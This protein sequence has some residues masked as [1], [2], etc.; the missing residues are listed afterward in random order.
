MAK[1]ITFAISVSEVRGAIEQI[2]QYQNELNRKCELLCQRLS[3]EGI[4]IAYAF[5]LSLK[6][7]GLMPK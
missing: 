3:A 2:R 6:R 1:K 4:A 5:L 7:N